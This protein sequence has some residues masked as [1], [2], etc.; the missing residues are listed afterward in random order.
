MKPSSAATE[1]FWRT[2]PLE[3]MDA[4]Q[5]ESL[6]DGCGRCCLVKLQ[7][8]DT[9]HLYATDIGCRLF[10]A[11]SCRCRDYPNRS[12][13]VPDCITLTP[14]E[15]RTL[16]WLPPTC[17]YRLV[18][19]GKDLPWWHPLVSGDPE[20][21]VA[22]GISVRDRVFANEDE[23]PEE[24]VAERIVAWPLRWPRGARARAAK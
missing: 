14:Q 22:A 5:W 18:A 16:P 10:D 3:A 20:T 15:V 21:V 4:E 9:G 17:A 24:E 6:C 13:A 2:T 23:V 8:E 12:V 7:D 11:G 1:P 19:E